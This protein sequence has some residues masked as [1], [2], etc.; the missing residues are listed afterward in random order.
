VQDGGMAM[1]SFKKS[2]HRHAA[3][4]RK[5]RIERQLLTCCKLDTYAMVRLWQVFSG[6]T[7]L[8]F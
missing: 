7:D 8:N 2:I 1:N 3:P 4:E 6:R 5:T